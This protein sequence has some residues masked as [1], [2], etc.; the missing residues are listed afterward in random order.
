MDGDEL[1][2]LKNLIHIRDQEIASLNQRI[3]DLLKSANERNKVFAALSEQNAL[4]KNT[5]DAIESENN[6]VC[7][8]RKK[9][10]NDDVS[11]DLTDDVYQQTGVNSQTIS[12]PVAGTSSTINSVIND[13]W[14][15][16]LSK[17]QIKANKKTNNNGIK[18]TP[19][20]L[21][22]MSND[23]LSVITKQLI[24][25]FGIKN[26]FIQ[27]L[28]NGSNPRIICDN[29]SIKKEIIDYLVA[30]Q[31]QFNTYNNINDRKKSFIIRGIFDDDDDEN[32][33]GISH[34]LKMV[35]VVDEFSVTRFITGY[36]KNNPGL[37]HNILY[38]VTV[39]SKVNDE[40]LLSI[41]TIGHYGVK[42]E[43][44]KSSKVIQCHNC[45]RFNHTS[46]QCFYNYR[47]VQCIGIH[48]YNECPR[49]INKNLPLGCVNC[50]ES[51]LEYNLH[52][53]NDLQNCNFYKQ[54]SNNNTSLNINSNFSSIKNKNANYN[55]INSNPIPGNS[56][57]NGQ[58]YS[59][60]LRGSK[61]TS[62][63]L[64][65]IISIAVKNTLKMLN[66]G[67]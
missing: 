67:S 28:K 52:T 11:I 5:I 48:N 8:K 39:G 42:F 38:R 65:E 62:N 1:C 60:V 7:V 15:V 66:Y 24:N 64:S 46:G 26:Y 30:Q 45:L 20:Q 63:E 36:Q 17:Q 53:A 58:S 16:V 55:Q 57:S 61:F 32:K 40:I 14:N 2:E 4:L 43:K 49:K 23:S 47:C 59:T 34:A 13:N 22:K 50:Y 12:Q 31:Y 21:N 54:I 51:K 10:T 35:G 3:N 56:I 37:N 41:R 18:V 27:Q 19:I 33:A 25:K 6:N 44:M 29:E 9:T